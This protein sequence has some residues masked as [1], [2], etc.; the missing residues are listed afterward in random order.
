MSPSDNRAPDSA[1]APAPPADAQGHPARVTNLVL[2]TGKGGSGVTTLAAATAAHGAQRGMRTLLLSLGSLGSDGD[3]VDLST[4]LDHP[5]GPVP[6]Q[7]DGLLYAQAFA[8]Q[9]AFEQ[10]YAVAVAKVRSLVET[11]G[12]TPPDAAELLAPPGAGEPLA[13][14]EIA[15]AVDGGA[16]DLVVVDGP[17]L[18]QAVRLLTLPV[19]AR[20]WLSR[21]RPVQTQAARALRP[22]L[23]TFAG[24][25]LP[26]TALVDLTEWMARECAAVQEVL[27]HQLSSVRLVATPDI[28]GLDRLRAARCALALFGLR[29]DALM[30][31]R[32]VLEAPR[33][34]WSRGWV[35]AQQI[36]ADQLAEVFGGVAR[37][38]VPYRPCE[39]LGLEELAVVA[40]AAYGEA[41]GLGA[42][43]HP[44]EPAV[45][46][47]GDG[48]VLS[49]PLP[50][51]DRRA[52]GLLRR[53]EEI[54]LTVGPY[55]R[56]LRLEPVLRRCRIAGA[57][58]RNQALE[59]RFVPDP[60]Q[61]PAPA[62]EPASGSASGSGAG[63]GPGAPAPGASGDGPAADSE[64]PSPAASPA[65]S[66]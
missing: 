50:G 43:G 12:L 44:P 41:D 39:P 9:A 33:D 2:F 32:K 48:Y 47:N 1:A 3:G 10:W 65:A 30:V 57:V 46:K 29:L 56:T 28:V 37:H 19:A 24:L 40:A 35:A 38:E 42:P 55:R 20:D 59:I 64:G 7:V 8:P 4:V 6:T 22:M 23:A 60:Q 58:L 53:D 36:A 63:F 51:A 45:A 27:A 18:G 52:M 13:L 11:I 54:V 21:T 14:A 25:P 5:V 49:V 62:G 31:N 15:A 16:W 34:S 26:Q 17:P 66:P 61:W